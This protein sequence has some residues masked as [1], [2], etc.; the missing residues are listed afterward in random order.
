MYYAN[1]KQV[2]CDVTF[3]WNA[4]EDILKAKTNPVNISQ[5]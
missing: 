3:D 4:F 2:F 5:E 1:F